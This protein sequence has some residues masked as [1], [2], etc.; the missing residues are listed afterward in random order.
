MNYQIKNSIFLFAIGFSF[1]LSTVFY[2]E[3]CKKDIKLLRQKYFYKCNGWCLNH[4]LS[5]ITLGYFSPN[6]WFEIILISVLF[7]FIEIYLNKFS[8]YINGNILRDATINVLSVFFGLFL[9]KLF[10]H[11]IDILKFITN[12]F[13]KIFNKIKIM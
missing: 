1:W 5:Y 8:K 6:Y 9:F 13:K 2:C 3:T 7:E 12:F 4:I 10:P 11:K